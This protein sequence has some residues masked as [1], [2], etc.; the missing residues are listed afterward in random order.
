[1]SKQKSGSAATSASQT[2]APESSVIGQ[3]V[4]SLQGLAENQAQLGQQVA[5]LQTQNLFLSQQMAQ[6][7]STLSRQ[8]NTLSS[9]EEALRA[10]LRRFQTGGPQH[11]MAAVF[12]KL[13]RDLLGHISQLDALVELGQKQAKHSETEQSWV[14]AICALQG[15]FEATL[16]AWGCTPVQ[17][18]ERVTAFDPECHEAVPAGED[19]LPEGPPK[20]VIVRV[21][22]RGWKLHGVIIQFPQVIVS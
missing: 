10:E 16:S 7:T 2:H 22:R 5:S 11:A 9:G 19:E 6:M 3:I 12:H 14:E 17:I 1:M 15:G 8:V 20:G 13:F 21:R 18:E 4:A